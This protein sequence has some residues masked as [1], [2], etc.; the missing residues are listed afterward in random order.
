MNERATTDTYLGV[1]IRL[2]SGRVLECKP[3]PLN[4]GLLWTR[5]RAYSEL[6][7]KNEDERRL[8]RQA[9]LQ[10]L[11]NFA[12]EVA[13]EGAE[14]T[15]DDLLPGEVYVL[16][17]RFLAFRRTDVVRGLDPEAGASR[18]TGAPS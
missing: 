15:F 9:Q 11:E 18:K 8:K 10:I 17:D 6:E 1:Q 16:I 7:P 4:R 12:A 13:P 2:P 14:E 5:V 3:L